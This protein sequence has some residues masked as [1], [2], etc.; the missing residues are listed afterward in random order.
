[1]TLIFSFPI[2]GFPYN[3]I[4][5]CLLIFFRSPQNLL[6]ID[7]LPILNDRRLKRVSKKPNF[8]KHDFEHPSLVNFLTFAKRTKSD[9]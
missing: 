4:A 8:D 3:I 5:I 1:V 6:K 7:K 2:L 9:S